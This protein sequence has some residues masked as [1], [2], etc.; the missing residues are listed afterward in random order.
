MGDILEF[1]PRVASRNVYEAQIEYMYAPE[2]D[3]ERP[4]AIRVLCEH[5]GS[6]VWLSRE[7]YIALIVDLVDQLN[8]ECLVD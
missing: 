2:I 8:E 4:Y 7:E 6:G 3:V 5:P 1:K